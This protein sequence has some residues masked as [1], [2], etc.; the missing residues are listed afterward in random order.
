MAT[1]ESLNNKLGL[2]SLVKCF[3]SKYLLLNIFLIFAFQ[4]KIMTAVIPIT[5]QEGLSLILWVFVCQRKSLYILSKAQQIWWGEGGDK[6]ASERPSCWG[7]VCERPGSIYWWGWGW[8]SPPPAHR[9]DVALRILCLNE[10][11]C[12]SLWVSECLLGPSSI[13]LIISVVFWL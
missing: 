9:L 10:E 12:L 5:C 13:L 11:W 6:T 1:T 2:Y 3:L 4:Q 7:D 8:F